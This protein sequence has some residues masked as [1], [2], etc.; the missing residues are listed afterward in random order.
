MQHVNTVIFET[1]SHAMSQNIMT[2]QVKQI[3]LIIP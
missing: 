1:V 3:S 2:S